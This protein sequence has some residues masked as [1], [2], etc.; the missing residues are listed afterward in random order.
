MT[1][2]P[3]AEPR[4][5]LKALSST[6]RK[7]HKALVDFETVRF[8]DPGS[9]FEHLQLLTS[10]PQFAWLRQ[11]SEILVEIDERL[12]NKEEPVDAAAL[13]TVRKTVGALLA[14]GPENGS[15][16]HQKYLDALQASPQVA[17]AHGELRHLLAASRP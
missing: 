10:H 14:L 16:F 12:D 13:E 11:I 17:M 5:Q 15:E 8:G 1:T 4:A 6:L 3:I 7:L 2:D 9:A